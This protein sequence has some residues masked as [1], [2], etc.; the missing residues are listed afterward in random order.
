MTLRDVLANLPVLLLTLAALTGSYALLCA[1][2]PFGRCRACSGTGQRPTLGR[3]RRPCLRCD[4]T[5]RRIRHG[6][7]LH[8]LWRRLYR[9]G[10]R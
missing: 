10:T 9:E 8:N 1:A 4:A 2:S 6:R 5:G 7:H 3:I